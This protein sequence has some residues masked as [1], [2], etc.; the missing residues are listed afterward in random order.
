MAELDELLLGYL[1]RHYDAVDG[2]EK[3]A[4][5]ALLRLSDPELVA[6]LLQKETPGPELQR[7]V[8]RILDRTDP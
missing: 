3:Q 5:H 2:S 6:Y 4:F 7:V 8:E 1:E